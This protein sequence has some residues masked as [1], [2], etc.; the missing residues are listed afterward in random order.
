MKTIIGLIVLLTLIG[1]AKEEP[2][3]PQQQLVAKQEVTKTSTMLVAEAK[4]KV[5][6]AKAKLAEEGKYTCCIK[7]GCNMCML[8]HGECDCYEGLKKGEHVCTE[9]Y[10]GWQQGKGTD[11]T[12]KKENVTTSLVEHH[13]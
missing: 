3:Q 11:A 1:C 13:H 8:A 10:V 12:I 7:E 5:I 2:K 4:E 6:E 9:C